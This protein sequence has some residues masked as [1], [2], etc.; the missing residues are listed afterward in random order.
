[1]SS[2][3]ATWILLLA[4]DVG[5]S[6]TLAGINEKRLTMMVKIIA[7]SFIIRYFIL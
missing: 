2:R 5:V 3:S 1:V 6:S 4:E 7:E